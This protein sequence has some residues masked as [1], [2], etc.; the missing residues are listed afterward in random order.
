[1][2]IEQRCRRLKTIY[3]IY[4]AFTATVDRA[5]RKHCALC[6]TCNV[7]ATTVEGWLIHDVLTSGPST[8]GVPAAQWAK[9]APRRFQPLVTINRLAQICMSGAE[10]VE[11][12][13]D[14]DA[15]P[16]PLLAGNICSIYAVR[17]FGCR[18]MLS[19]RDCACHG[20]ASM[21]DLVL[22]ANQVVMQYLEAL[23]RPG[24]TG[25]LIDVLLFLSDP[26]QQAA[27]LNSPGP[28][29]PHSLRLNQGFSAWLVPPEHRQA[30]RPLLQALQNLG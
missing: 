1:V 29:W 26:Q 9:K 20:E 3:E 16:C 17:P 2:D 25:N 27:Y 23:D 15:G 18:A 4:E 6:C 21:P 13:N 11:E 30:I 10:P 22:S 12:R 14:P 19:T 28:S 8:P 7:T 24:A 5:C